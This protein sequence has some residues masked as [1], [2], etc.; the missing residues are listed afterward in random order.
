M[1]T[2]EAK[3]ASVN[4]KGRQI[5]EKENQQNELNEIYV[6]LEAGDLSVTDAIKQ[7]NALTSEMI[8]T[9]AVNL[10]NQQTREVLI[11]RDISTARNKFHETYPDYSEVVESGKLQPYI[12]KSP[13]FIDETVAYFQYKADQKFEEGKVETKAE[14]IKEPGAGKKPLTES[15][16]E[17]EQMRTVLNMRDRRPTRQEPITL[18][19][20]ENQQMLTLKEM[21]GLE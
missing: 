19:E 18:K 7:S 5:M 10:A 1:R 21:R 16:L 14:T 2:N 9:G 4:F 13:M 20:I 11:T 17:A 6:K 12:D 15:E 8:K 3:T